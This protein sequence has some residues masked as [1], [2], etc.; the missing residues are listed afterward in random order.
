MAV[1]RGAMRVLLAALAAGAL[2][3]A[4]PVAQRWPVDQTVHYVLDDPP[5]AVLELDA[6]WSEPD[7]AVLREVSLRNLR[8][9]PASALTDHFRL[10]SGA[11][12][13]EVD[14]ETEGGRVAVHRKSHVRLEGGETHIELLDRGET[15]PSDTR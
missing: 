12:D 3:V 7:G 4:M 5:G 15:R 13:V 10:P 2:L 14:V 9:A 1:P 8:G 6:R 11:Y